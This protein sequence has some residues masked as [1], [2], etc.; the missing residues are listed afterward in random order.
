MTWRLLITPPSAGAW[1]MAVD[2]ALL[3]STASH[4]SPPTLRLYDWL[5]DC[6]SLGYAQPVNEIN[7]AELQAQ[8]WDLVRRPTG[9]RA[10]LHRLEIT[11]SI[12][13]PQTTPLVA[14]SLLESYRRISNTLLHVLEVLGID[15]QAD[16]EY[17]T[18][19]PQQRM[20]PVCFEV[21]SNYE[22]TANGKK[23][24]GSAQARKAGGVLQH[25]SL[26]LE[27]EIGL[28]TKA[29]NFPSEN[30]RQAAQKR[31]ETHATTLQSVIGRRISWS[32]AALAFQLA[33]SKALEEPLEQGELLEAEK[34]LVKDLLT[35]KYSHPSW[36][37]RI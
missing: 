24:I 25:G 33:F 34:S 5:P 35:S 30:E 3:L 4:Q 37:E 32:E 20:Q 21:P 12:T 29:L 36:N 6:L 26:P 9:G 22:I 16:K 15:A 27:G 1:N 31:V 18:L 19:S 28:I 11:Y 7:H 14:G 13:A 2:E 17:S 8:G 23:L 10:I